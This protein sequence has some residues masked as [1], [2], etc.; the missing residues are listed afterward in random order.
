[1]NDRVNIKFT[2]KPDAETREA[3]KA[4]KFRWSPKFGVWYA[5]DTGDYSELLEYIK[6]DN[7][8]MEILHAKPEAKSQSKT[9]GKLAPDAIRKGTHFVACWGYDQTQYS[10]YE[11]VSDQQGQ[12]IHVTGL[13][14]WSTLD[15]YQLAA[16]SKVKLLR[17]I[18]GYH[19]L[20]EEERNEYS[21]SRNSARALDWSDWN[22]YAKHW[23]NDDKE[24]APEKTI[25]KV[26]RIDGDKYSYLWTFE[27][28]TTWSSKERYNS[29]IRCIVEYA[30]TRKKV[31]TS[32]YN[33]SKYIKIDSVITA[34][35]DADYSTNEEKY[36]KQNEYTDYNGR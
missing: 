8:G 6:P 30:V 21:A 19:S 16:G 9:A 14:D 33:G 26:Q 36:S 13:N 34:Y 15:D 12:F 20:T 3:L 32:G 17:S 1:M 27:D 7:T 35:L 10:I 5:P 4:A 22:A 11:A 25:A 24:A 28:G 2:G 31:Q 23:W 29:G 18:P